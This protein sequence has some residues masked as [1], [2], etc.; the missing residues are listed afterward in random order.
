MICPIMIVIGHTFGGQ[1]CY[2]G[3]MSWVLFFDGDC[4]F[5][6]AGVRQAMKFDRHER[7]KFSPLQGRLAEE[8][9]FT[10][11]SDEAD[12]TMVL[13]REE[14]G[15]VYLRS[16]A[17][18]QLTQV[19]GGAWLIFF[20]AFLIPRFIRDAAYKWVARNRYLFSGKKDFCVFP[21]PAFEARVI[22]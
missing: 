5:C 3:N 11:F 13:M 7:L 14:D 21:D 10:E 16:D 15:R 2:L 1:V 19:F 22:E 6:S 20:P 12:G 18:I 8:K 4:A 17:A 9:G